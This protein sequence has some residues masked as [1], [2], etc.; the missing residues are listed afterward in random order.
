MH[1]ETRWGSWEGQMSEDA[2]VTVVLTWSR[3]AALGSDPA[4]RAWLREQGLDTT[5][6][7]RVLR[8]NEATALVYTGARI[9]A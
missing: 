9:P 8:D 6:E 4:I 5:R 7:M 2:T 3:A 1:G